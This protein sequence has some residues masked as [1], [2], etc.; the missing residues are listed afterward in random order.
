LLLRD[1]LVH[2]LRQNGLTTAGDG[3][4]PASPSETIVSVGGLGH[5]TPM[6]AEEVATMHR[7]SLAVVGAPKRPKLLLCS[8][9]RRSKNMLMFGLLGNVIRRILL[10]DRLA[11]W[12]LFV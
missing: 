5:G 9:P 6:N 4:G 8:I 10:S 12:W 7:T 3:S 11:F 2:L 1:H